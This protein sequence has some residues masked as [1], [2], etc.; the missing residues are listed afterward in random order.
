ML[1]ARSRSIWSRNRLPLSLTLSPEGERE[2]PSRPRQ[3]EDSLGDDS[4]L[5]LAGAALDRIGLGPE[6]LARGLALLRA[7][8]LPIEGTGAA[9]RHHQLVAALVEFGPRIFH[10]RG[11]GRVRHP[12][13][14][15][16]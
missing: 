9:W 4:E 7:L 8:A 16:V 3:I 6:P 5:D 13:F 11:L 1:R 10:H 2:R 12:G 15:F 14:E